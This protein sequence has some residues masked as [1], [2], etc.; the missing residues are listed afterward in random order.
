MDF[1]FRFVTS[2]SWLGTYYVVQAGLEFTAISCLSLPSVRIPGTDCNVG[3]RPEHHLLPDSE[4]YLLLRGHWLWTDVSSH[5]CQQ[6][7][8]WTDSR[9]MPGPAH[10]PLR[11]RWHA[12]GKRAGWALCSSHDISGFCLKACAFRTQAGLIPNPKV[13]N[14]TKFCHFLPQ[15]SGFTT[16]SGCGERSY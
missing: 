9:H 12:E 15:K 11:L 16:T 6:T 13:T 1:F 7:S 8:C 2:S 4:G 10:A 3:L 14:I 5:C